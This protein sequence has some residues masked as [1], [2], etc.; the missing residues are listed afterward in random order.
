MGRKPRKEEKFRRKRRDIKEIRGNWREEKRK[1][2]EILSYKRDLSIAAIVVL[3][4][5]FF[6]FSNLE[7]VL[8]RFERM[9]LFKGN[10]Q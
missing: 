2:K 7:D 3:S 9:V 1:S 5:V 10:Y 4:F 6:P 8:F